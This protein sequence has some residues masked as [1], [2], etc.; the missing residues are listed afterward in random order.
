MIRRQAEASAARDHNAP[1]KLRYLLES[2][3][4]RA[5]VQTAPPPTVLAESVSSPGADGHHLP[6]DISSIGRSHDAMQSRYHNMGSCHGSVSVSHGRAGGGAAGSLD[7]S[8]SF[9]R[10]GESMAESRSIRLSCGGGSFG[11][12]VGHV[13]MELTTG[14]TKSDLRYRRIRLADGTYSIHPVR[15]NKS[16]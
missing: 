15:A 4:M 5:E 12:S 9:M 10:G 16:L 3:T 2:P 13:G 1:H 8:T 14:T 11:N 6:E 7:D